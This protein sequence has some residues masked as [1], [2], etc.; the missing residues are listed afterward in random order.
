MTL[1]FFLYQLCF[2]L[3]YNNTLVGEEYKSKFLS[4][5]FALPLI[6]TVLHIADEDKFVFYV[7][8][9]DY[10]FLHKLSFW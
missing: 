4:E 3:K 8:S 9:N 1:F 2:I 10:S 6:V 7:P 5:I